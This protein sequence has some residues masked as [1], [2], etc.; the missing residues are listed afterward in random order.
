[1][2]TFDPAIALEK[3]SVEYRDRIE[4]LRQDLAR[5]HSTDSA[6][7]AVERENDEVLEALLSESEAALRKVEKARERL[8]EGVYGQCSKCG[9]AIS[10][11]R[12]AVMPMAERCV[13]CAD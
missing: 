10:V 11:G 2:T 8:H 7:Q 5:S 13:Q 3:M 6:E 12:L 4:A 9:E 1:V